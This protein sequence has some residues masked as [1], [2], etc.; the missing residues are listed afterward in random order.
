MILIETLQAL[1]DLVVDNVG[2]P[3]FTSNQKDIFLQRAQQNLLNQ[4][5]NKMS[6]GHMA[7]A[8]SNDSDSISG[9]IQEVILQTNA[10]GELLESAISTALNG[11]E[12]FRYLSV[13]RQGILDCDE[14]YDKSRFVRHNDFSTNQQNSFKKATNDFPIHRYY[15]SKLQFN[16]TGVANIKITVILF[17]LLMT[18]DD[19][20]DSGVRGSNAIDSELDDDRTNEIAYLALS[21]AGINIRESDFYQ[22]VEREGTRNE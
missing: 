5:F 19:P 16:P 15:N 11:R 2:S 6:K 12:K 3:Y 18:L 9:L 20:T 17:P 10:Q 22:M 13:Q 21:M 1:F 4:Y 8:T 14:G 7:E